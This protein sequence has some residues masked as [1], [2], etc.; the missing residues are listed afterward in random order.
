[1]HDLSLPI[2]CIT[3]L[4]ETQTSAV[5]IVLLP[6]CSD[7]WSTALAF[8]RHSP[9]SV[10]VPSVSCFSSTFAV[11][12]G[13][14]SFS[15]KNNPVYK[16]TSPKGIVTQLQLALLPFA[17][18][19]PAWVWI[20][21]WDLIRRARGENGLSD[22]VRRSPGLFCHSSWL[23]SIPAQNRLR[24]QKV[25]VWLSRTQEAYACDKGNWSQWDLGVRKIQGMKA[26][27]GSDQKQLLP[28]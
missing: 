17:V 28:K 25:F 12:T 6:P 10:P 11:Q 14:A 23:A 15:H 2:T 7:N 21:T 18:V 24:R 5:K 9:R 26:K 16:K 13:F 1:M 4:G 27:K 20:D 8:L 19:R 22:L 3:T